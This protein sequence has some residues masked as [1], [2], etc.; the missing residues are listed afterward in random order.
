MGSFFPDTQIEPGE[1][2]LFKG[3]SNRSQGSRAVRGRLFVTDRLVIF[4][5][6]AFDQRTGGNSW[7]CGLREIQGVGTAKRTL[8][9]PFSAGVRKRLELKLAE[10]RQELFGVNHLE[11]VEET[12]RDAISGSSSAHSGE[13]QD[14]KVVRHHKVLDR[15]L[16]LRL[17]GPVSDPPT[18]R[19]NDPSERPVGSGSGT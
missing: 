13:A 2:I 1:R 16:F 4:A 18:R 15:R 17:I 12:L 9:K 5:P 6:N 11:A 3:R 8:E 19:Q 10:N 14:G 7:S